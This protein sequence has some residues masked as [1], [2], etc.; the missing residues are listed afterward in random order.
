MARGGRNPGM[1][2]KFINFNRNKRSIVLDLKK[3]DGADGDAALDRQRRR[4]R[5]QRAARRARARR[6][7]LHRAWRR[8]SPRL[9]HC[10]ILRASAAAASYCNRP[11]YDPI[12]QSLSG[13]RRHAGA[14]DRRAAL[15]A[16]W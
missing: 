13:R 3:P 9:I 10:S 5:E 15:R 6:P 12:V 4:V 8:T 14:R 7:R 2:G 11:A 1:S 16:A